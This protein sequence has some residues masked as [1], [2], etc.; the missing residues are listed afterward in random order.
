LVPPFVSLPPRH[1]SSELSCPPCCRGV[2]SPLIPSP[3]VLRLY[4]HP[5]FMLCS[6]SPPLLDICCPSPP[7][8][9]LVHFPSF[10]LS[11][12]PL[13]FSSFL[14]SISTPPDVLSERP[15]WGCFCVLYPRESVFSMFFLFSPLTPLALWFSF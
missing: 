5:P 4:K 14:F 13:F 6:S 9:T 3:P 1:P 2:P 11:Q 15:S 8:N 10:L 12:T 7:F